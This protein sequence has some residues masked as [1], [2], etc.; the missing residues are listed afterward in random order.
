MVG[1][2]YHITD[3]LVRTQSERLVMA[4]RTIGLASLIIRVNHAWINQSSGGRT[5]RRPISHRCKWW[6]PQVAASYGNHGRAM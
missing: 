1:D 2:I 6:T 4:K 3:F 5:L